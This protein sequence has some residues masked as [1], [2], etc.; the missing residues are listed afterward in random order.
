MS[1]NYLNFGVDLLPK[2][3]NT[4]NLGNTNYKWN[5]FIST[6][7]GSSI[8]DFLSSN[9][10]HNYLPLTGGTL[11]DNLT[12]Q[13][14]TTPTVAVTDPGTSVEAR[15]YVDDTHQNHGLYSTGYYD[16]AFNTNGKWMIYRDGNGNIIVNG[17]A[18]NVTG[19]VAIAN[20]GTGATTA[21]LAR[22]ALG[23]GTAATIAA[24]ISIAN[25]GTGKTTDLEAVTNLGSVYIKPTGTEITASSNLDS[26]Y[27]TIG[28][29][30]S[31]SST[32]SQTLSGTVPVTGSGFKLITYGGYRTA[33]LR[34]FLAGADYNLYYR[35]SQD[36][37]GTWTK[38]YKFVLLPSG[39]DS[40][41]FSAIG[42]SKTPVYVDAE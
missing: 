28:S 24:P 2:T 10:T 6:I 5:I 7:N 21:P 30:Y 8:S 40:K 42:G 11:S 35:S 32:R 15:L 4:Y 41:T 14:D 23:L 34:Q 12:I 9:H 18:E 19:V 29:Y 38:W 20:G 22:T 27:K 36:T 39:S 25:G 1:N 17:K 33:T 31:G 37:G 13:K 16:T 26:G 3:D